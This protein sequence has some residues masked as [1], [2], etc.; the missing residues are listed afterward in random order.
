MSQDVK[1]L[2]LPEG[3]DS[4]GSFVEFKSVL[5]D[6]ASANM[7]PLLRE[8]DALRNRLE[9]TV[10]DLTDAKAENERLR[11]DAERYRWLRMNA[12]EAWEAETVLQ[13][14]QAGGHSLDARIDEDMANEADQ[15]QGG[16]S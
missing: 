6:Y 11:A 16:E 3:Y 12:N 13:V 7:E 4:F 2:P 8:R 5:H 14:V 9:D 1:L 10:R 15:Q